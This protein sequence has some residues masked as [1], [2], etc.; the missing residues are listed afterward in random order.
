MTGGPSAPEAFPVPFKIAIA[1]VI[2]D[3]NP[4]DIKADAIANMFMYS[5][6]IPMKVVINLSVVIGSKEARLIAGI[7]LCK[8]PGCLRRGQY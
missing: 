7:T 2:P 4:F 6:H 5:Q 3:S 1:K 8:R